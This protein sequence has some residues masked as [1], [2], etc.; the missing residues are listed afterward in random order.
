MA[1]P[2]LINGAD[3]GP[4]N[5]LQSLTKQFDRDRG[6]Q[7]DQFGPGRAGPSRQVFRTQSASR[8]P[9]DQ[10]AA[11]FFSGSTPRIA[12]SP[13]HVVPNTFELFSL[14]DNLPRQ[15][16]SILASPSPWAGEFS[17]Q[18]ILQAPTTQMK[19]ESNSTLFRH[20]Y[21]ERMDAPRH[22]NTPLNAFFPKGG[23]RPYTYVSSIFNGIAPLQLLQAHD[24][25]EIILTQADFPLHEVPQQ[26]GQVT[27]DSDEL[28]RTAGLLI[29]T[30]KGETNPKFQN[31]AFL[32]LMRQLRDKEMVLEGTDMVKARFST[33]DCRPSTAWAQDFTKSAEV[34]EKGKARAENDWSDTFQE[35]PSLV[36]GVSQIVQGQR[37]VSQLYPDF[38][39]N[40]S[41]YLL[42]EYPLESSTSSKTRK[43]V[44]FDRP[45]VIRNDTSSQGQTIHDVENADSKFW[46]QENDEYQNYWKDRNVPQ[47]LESL[48]AAPE[49][50]DKLQADW[51]HF[52]ATATGIKPV[53]MYQ[54]QP[55]NRYLVGDSSTHNHVM[56]TQRSH[57]SES[58]LEKEAAVQNDRQNPVAWFELGVK[59]QENER[60]H[61]AIQALQRAVELEPSYLEAWLALAISHTN[62]GNKNGAYNAIEHWVRNNEQ[63]EGGRLMSS[64]DKSGEKAVSVRHDDL[65][66]CLMRLAR[67]AQDGEVDADIQ[68]ALGVLLNTSEDYEKAQDCFRAALAVRPNDWLLYNRVGATLANSGRSTDALWYY[69]RALELNPS[70]IRARFNIGISCINMKRY[71]EAAV[72]I[73]D[74]LVLQENDASHGTDA[75]GITSSALW[76]CLR[77]TCMQLQR[78]ELAS[79]CDLHDLEVIIGFRKAFSTTSCSTFNPELDPSCGSIPLDVEDIHIHYRIPSRSSRVMASRF[80]LASSDATKGAFLSSFF[81]DPSR[82]ACSVAANFFLAISSLT[83]E[84]SASPRGMRVGFLRIIGDVCGG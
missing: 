40:A 5:P 27:V 29:E 28:S 4:L 75:R 13:P 15:S 79:L 3:C 74:A 51:D 53:T 65:I 45:E 26:E 84:T 70:Y 21:S 54:F 6:I 77:T 9:L 64:L 33:V 23:Y 43:P 46:K 78:P 38:V 47:R 57:S 82:V 14:R 73:L 11:Q 18:S 19:T 16:T 7:Q 8:P 80:R 49:E 76:E 42:N 63:Y 60:E 31:S 58:I 69:H 71:V 62:E 22:N 20:P 2:A 83:S 50:W 61:S 36:S 34:K 66:Q 17:K 55:N 48:R 39:T 59:Q 35:T 56:H 37:S 68:T 12:F 72:H 44:H 41:Q 52:E 25:T 1:L 24:E 67:S 32:G 81:F 30:V 10:E